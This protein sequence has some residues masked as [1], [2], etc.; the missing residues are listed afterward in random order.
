MQMYAIGQN[1]I[2]KNKDFEC[3]YKES[4]TMEWHM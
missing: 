4:R 3:Q 2:Y 1:I